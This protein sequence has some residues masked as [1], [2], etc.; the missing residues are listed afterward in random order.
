MNHEQ[1]LKWLQDTYPGV[2]FLSFVDMMEQFPEYLLMMH[3]ETYSDNH[4]QW[5]HWKEN[6]WVDIPENWQPVGFQTYTIY[7]VGDM[8]QGHQWLGQQ[9][10]IESLF[11]KDQYVS[12]SDWI[13][14]TVCFNEE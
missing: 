3:D 4:T 2:K 5:E 7:F 12:G 9:L 1:Q 10:L 6:L 8:H 14:I 13:L 11:V